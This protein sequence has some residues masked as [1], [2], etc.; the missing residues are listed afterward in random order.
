MCRNSG[1][2]AYRTYEFEKWDTELG[3]T[4]L[5]VYRD[6]VGRSMPLLIVGNH[7]GDL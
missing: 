5:V 6:S 4:M 2:G 1:C 7:H 3:L